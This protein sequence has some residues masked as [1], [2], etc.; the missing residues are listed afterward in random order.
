MFEILDSIAEFMG[1]AL[2]TVLL[3]FL[4]M[5]AVGLEI[6]EWV[7]WLKTRRRES[8]SSRLRKDAEL[9]SLVAGTASMM[10]FALY[11]MGMARWLSGGKDWAINVFILS[12]AGAGW[13]ALV[14]SGFCRAGI[15]IAGISAGVLMGWFWW[16]LWDAVGFARVYTPFGTG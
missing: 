8:P 16:V 3:I 9:T 2:T 4:P 12:G 7:L 15:R 5:L 13:L 14:A 10:L 1:D 11:L 6:W